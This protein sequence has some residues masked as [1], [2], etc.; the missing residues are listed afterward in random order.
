[1]AINEAKDT[2]WESLVS[3]LKAYLKLEPDIEFVFF[4]LEEAIN[5]VEE[6]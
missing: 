1:M 6:D 3:A 2:A 4:N 5:T